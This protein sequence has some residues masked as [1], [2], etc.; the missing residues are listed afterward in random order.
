ME[1][2]SNRLLS[3]TEMLLDP[4]DSG[5]QEPQ[6]APEQ[7]RCIVHL[8]LD[9]FY[10]AVEVIDHPK[11]KSKPI[12]IGGRPHER[13]VVS[14]ASYEARRYGVRSAMPMAR[15]LQICPSAIVLPP[16]H[17][18]YRRY[19][20][21]VMA[22]LRQVTE[23][24]EQ[25]SID[26]AYLDLSELLSTWE[27]GV[28][29]AGTLQTQVRE[30]VGLSA[31]LG[32]ATNK[33][34]A[35]VAS[36]HNKPG[37][38]TV[39]RP[40]EEAAFLAPL[41]VRVLSGIGPVTASRLA[42]MGVNTVGDLAA[43][44]EAVLHSRF[45][46]QGRAMA[47]HS[48]GID[49]RAVSTERVAKSISQERTFSRD[50]ADEDALRD[51]LR[52]LSE[53]VSRRLQAAGLAAGTLSLKLRYANFDTLTRQKTLQIAT[54]DAK[55]IHRAALTLLERAWQRGQPVRLL[56]ITGQQL[57]PPPHQQPHQLSLW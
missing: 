30:Q 56:G 48:R 5:G 2:L 1:K 45:G 35:K 22:L 52:R 53:G 29:I 11:Y 25:T 23:R 14:T 3:Y 34:V 19:S 21:R 26:E 12:V 51:E 24:V 40:G 41:P 54:N 4:I 7:P 6:P 39:V 15:A 36:D 27:T 17:S 50:L 9:A 44:P 43:V 18:A 57:V 42:E 37:G 46:K 20:R 38:L 10:A 8:D 47:D 55:E 16:R 49:H 33:L 13:G 28:E 31:S 32:V